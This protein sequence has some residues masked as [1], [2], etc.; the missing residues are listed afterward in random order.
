MKKVYIIGTEA[1]TLSVLELAV[2]YLHEKDSAGNSIWEVQWGYPDVKF[3]EKSLSLL[4]RYN[5]DWA[6]LIIALVE[7][8]KEMHEATAAAVAYASKLEKDVS[9]KLID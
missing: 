9:F 8:D 6:D 4:V 7:P 5:I 1:Q 2:H 3:T